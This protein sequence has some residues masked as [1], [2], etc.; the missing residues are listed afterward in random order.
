M[1]HSPTPSGDSVPISETPSMYGGTTSTSETET[2]ASE[3][4]MGYRNKILEAIQ[5]KPKSYYYIG[6]PKQYFWLIQHIAAQSN[7]KKLYIIQYYLYFTMHSVCF[8]LSSTNP[9]AEST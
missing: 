6:L 1:R 5:N 7:V 8:L 4:E 9:T 2:K 3:K